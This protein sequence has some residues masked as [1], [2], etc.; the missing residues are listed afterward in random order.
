MPNL[1]TE[2]EESVFALAKALQV[3]TGRPLIQVCD[4]FEFKLPTF[5]ECDRLVKKIRGWY[6]TSM[7]ATLVVTDPSFFDQSVASS[8]TKAI[9]SGKLFMTQ[10]ETSRNLKRHP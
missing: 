6:N 1:Q 7:P 4:E 5:T 2:F 10:P 9:S 3:P 8:G